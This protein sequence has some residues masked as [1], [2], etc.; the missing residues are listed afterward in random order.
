MDISIDQIINHENQI[1]NLK[2]DDILKKI[3]LFDVLTLLAKSWYLISEN[4]IKNCQHEAGIL[5][6]QAP[7]EIQENSIVIVDKD[8]NFSN[9][10][11]EIICRVDD[12]ILTQDEFILSEIQLEK[13]NFLKESSV[14]ENIIPNKQI[15]TCLILLKEAS[16]TWSWLSQ[17]N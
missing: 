16:A 10:E 1:I 7:P 6:S 11:D 13:E 14:V 4:T 12:A 3:N 17:R 15:N 5:N 9:Q 2:C 8:E